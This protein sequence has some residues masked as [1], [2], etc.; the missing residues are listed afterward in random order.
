VTSDYID[1]AEYL[2]RHYS[3]VPIVEV[4]IG[5]NF[6]VSKELKKHGHDVR[7][8]DINPSLEEVIKDDILNPDLEIYKDCGLIYSIRPPPELV[9]YIA[10]VAKVVGADLIIRPLSTDDAPKKGEL[11]NY[12]SAIFYKINL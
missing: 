12:K 10:A 6:E 11:K 7:S 4:G 8:I 1:F 3:N 9:S 2:A 5:S